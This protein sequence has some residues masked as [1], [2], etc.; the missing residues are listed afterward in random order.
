[1]FV[2]TQEKNP[3]H[4]TPECVEFKWSVKYLWIWLPNLSNCYF[5]DAKTSVFFLLSFVPAKTSFW[6]KI[7]II[8]LWGQMRLSRL[9]LYCCCDWIDNIGTSKICIFN[10]SKKKSNVKSLN[11]SNMITWTRMRIKPASLLCTTCNA[12]IY[13]SNRPHLAYILSNSFEK[14]FLK[15]RRFLP[16]PYAIIENRVCSLTHEYEQTKYGIYSLTGMKNHLDSIEHFK[17]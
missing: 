12:I 6:I 13:K 4:R 2:M 10:L 8:P 15:N 1:M 5:Y 3:W 7:S 11:I 16:L 9:V 17:L 14:V